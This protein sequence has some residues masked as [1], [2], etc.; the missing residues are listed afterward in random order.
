MMVRLLGVFLLFFPLPVPPLPSSSLSPPTNDNLLFNSEVINDNMIPHFKRRMAP[1][2]ISKMGLCNIFLLLSL[3]H[4][5]YWIWSLDHFCSMQQFWEFSY[6]WCSNHLLKLRPWRCDNVRE[7]TSL[8]TAALT[9]HE[10]PLCRITTVLYLSHQDLQIWMASQPC[11]PTLRQC[12]SWVF[13]E[14]IFFSSM[15]NQQIFQ[16]RIG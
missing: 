10:M 4:F 9:N 8:W 5:D 1:W 11:C 15:Q 3:N 12:I 14:D 6:I 7:E 16:G 2:Y 13:V